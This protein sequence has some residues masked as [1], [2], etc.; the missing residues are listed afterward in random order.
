[1]KIK[2]HKNVL[3]LTIFIKKQ[4]CGISLLKGIG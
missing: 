2:L 4:D 1:M 3:L